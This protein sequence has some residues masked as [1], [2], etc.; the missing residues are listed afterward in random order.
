VGQ[1]SQREAV[2]DSRDKATTFPSVRVLSRSVVEHNGEIPSSPL[3]QD[4]LYRTLCDYTFF[5]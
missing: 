4:K 2:G 1:S 3:V 5:S